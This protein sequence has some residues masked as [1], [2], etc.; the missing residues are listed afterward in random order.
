MHIFTSVI[1]IVPH[2]WT[3]NKTGVCKVQIKVS[4]DIPSLFASYSFWKC[5]MV[6][7]NSSNGKYDNKFNFV[8]IKKNYE[9]NKD[10][11]AAKKY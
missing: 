8:K 7:L 3:A 2:P 6:L 11:Q 5:F 10:L 1:K 9:K 4:Y